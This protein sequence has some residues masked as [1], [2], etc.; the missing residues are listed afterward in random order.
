[1]F[2]GVIDSITKT[3]SGRGAKISLK[4]RDFTQLMLDAKVPLSVIKD[5]PDMDMELNEWIFAFTRLHPVI[6]SVIS[7]CTYDASYPKQKA[8]ESEGFPDSKK[9]K[10]GKKTKKPKLF[11]GLSYWD[12]IIDVCVGSGF[13]PNVKG[14][15]IRLRMGSS[16]YGKES[17][18]DANFERVIDGKLSHVR[19]LTIGHDVKDFSITRTLDNSSTPAIRVVTS[20]GGKTISATYPIGDP[21]HSKHYNPNGDQ[22]ENKVEIVVVEGTANYTILLRTAKSL[23]EKRA[24]QEFTGSLT[25][26]SMFS[27]GGDWKDPDL[28]YLDPS[29]AIE[30][31]DKEDPLYNSSSVDRQKIKD[32]LKRLNPEDNDENRIYNAVAEY[33]LNNAPK[34]KVMRVKGVTHSFSTTGGYD[35]SI[36][37][38][39]W[40][41]VVLDAADKQFFDKFSKASG[42]EAATRVSEPPDGGVE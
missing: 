21:T 33:A 3:G 2:A 20:Y 11:T 10:K 17:W 13:I 42:A 12:V 34:S 18:E 23:W 27:D 14:T 7:A 39:N 26:E 15:E 19:R 9:T 38:H 35:C 36:D 40:Y 31:V 4:S 32:M 28:L 6:S 24:R 25:T 30:L 37:Y 8:L 16:F 5:L 22:Q 1:M 29:D 41:T